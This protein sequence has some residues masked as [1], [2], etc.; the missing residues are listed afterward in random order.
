[1]AIVPP[2][3]VIQPGVVRS[4]AGFPSG[5]VESRPVW[6]PGFWTWDGFEWV[7]VPAHWVIPRH[8]L[9]LRNPCD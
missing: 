6:V 5:V 8:Q 2:P 9:L 4:H 1:M 7:W 3:V